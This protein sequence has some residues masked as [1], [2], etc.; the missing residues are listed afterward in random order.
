[1]PGSLVKELRQVPVAPTVT[2]YGH[3][4]RTVAEIRKVIEAGRA[5]D[6]V[7]AP[8][9]FVIVYAGGQSD[10]IVSARTG[11]VGYYLAAGQNGA[12]PGHGPD[13]ATAARNAGLAAR[14]N[15]TAVADYLIFTHPLGASTFHPQVTRVPAGSVVQVAA[16]G[17]RIEPVASPEA[18]PRSAPE[19]TIEALLAAVAADIP[20]GCTLSM[21]GG[22]DSRLLL[23]ALL[24]LGHRPHLLVSGIPG[25]FDAV[26]ATAIGRRLGLPCSV[27]AI[28]ED[29]VVAGLPEI[30]LAS[31]GMIPGGNWAG[32]AHA[33]TAPSGVPLMFG[34]N[35]EIAR[36][37][38]SPHAGYRAMATARS[39]PKAGNPVL[40]GRRFASPFTIR[41]QRWLAP[42]LQAALEPAAIAARL[43]AAVGADH[44]SSAFAMGERLFTEH[45]GRQKIGN[46]LAA[47]AMHARWRAPLFAPEFA[48]CAL[49]LPSSWKLGSRWHRYA[50][51]RLY[52][53]LLDFPEEGYGP[54]LR[55]RPPVRYWL[56]GP[57]RPTLPFF[58]DH[59]IFTSPRLLGLLTAHASALS[60]LAD[61][62]LLAALGAEQAT[63]PRRPHAVFALQA[64]AL[65]RDAA[66]Y[67]APGPH[68]A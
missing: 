50:I 56:R 29:D 17:A 66:R 23:A 61:P 21:S 15:H 67:S 45:Y 42:E 11:I 57:G 7:D 36:A 22:L 14:W 33:R 63:T 54:G 60:G 47:I 62:E 48:R 51:A 13:A 4:A 9:N 49:A 55:S 52:P 32:L 44:L 26:V 58:L 53:Q 10:V 41:E 27:A 38:Y 59:A 18:R 64:L 65:W 34:F 37:Y 28:T 40:L 3:C 16:D 35:G 2:V 1:M 43:R 68:N 46:D 31:N 25:S 30:V 19:A 20:E 5:A 39:R 24:A 8:G 12:R 6:L